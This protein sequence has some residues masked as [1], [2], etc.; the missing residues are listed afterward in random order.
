ML[1]VQKRI[2]AND[3]VVLMVYVALDLLKIIITDVSASTAKGTEVEGTKSH[4]YQCSS[5]FCSIVKWKA[6]CDICDTHSP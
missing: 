6:S 3:A 1:D 5:V 2:S 4:S